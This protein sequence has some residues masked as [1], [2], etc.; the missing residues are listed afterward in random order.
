MKYRHCVMGLVAFLAVVSWW[1]AAP[2]ALTQEQQCMVPVHTAAPPSPAAING[3]TIPRGLASGRGIKVAVIDTGISPHPQL[4]HLQS[5]AD[6]VE[7]GMPQPLHDCDGHGTL[8]AG[9]IAAQD[10]G[11]APDA[12][13]LS[14][15]QSS[16]ATTQ[17]GEE[18][19]DGTLA[20]LAE[21]IDRAVEAQAN[22]INI[23]ITACIPAGQHVDLSGLHSAVQHAE[24]TGTVIVAAAGNEGQNCQPG[25][26][27]LPAHL[28]TVIAVGAMH[29]AYH[30]AS[31]SLP[32]PSSHLVLSAQGTQEIALSPDGNGWITGL[33]PP[34]SPQTQ[35]AIVGTSFA[36]PQVSG[37]IALM[38]ERNPQLS[39]A[40]IR[41]LLA[42]AATPGVGAI[43]PEIALSSVPFTVAS[44]PTA[45]EALPQAGITRSRVHFLLVLFATLATSI[46]VAAAV[47]RQP[48]SQLK[49]DT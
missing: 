6:L 18:S 38:R 31:Y 7:P 17:H 2:V 33:H 11:I 22:V 40:E 47:R 32:V 21:A 5:V 3:V 28:P 19:H 10:G 4:P 1:F 42:R 39:P 27:I 36:A 20:S 37:L 41:S 35:T 16:P 49:Y 14:I 13:L 26:L 23:S 25:A 48:G 24:D 46:F 15:K 9:I 45:A 29:D 30:Q 34:L 43:N 8:V 44:R 12:E